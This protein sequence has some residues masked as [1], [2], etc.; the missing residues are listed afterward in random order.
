MARVARRQV[1]PTGRIDLCA[2]RLLEQAMEKSTDIPLRSLYG[3]YKAEIDRAIKRHLGK[4]RFHM[5]E[6]VKEIVQAVGHPTPPP[7]PPPAPA[8]PRPRTAATGPVV[9][10]K[11]G[12]DGV[13]A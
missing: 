12:K 13:Y 5:P 6:P 9:E 11:Q 2:I 4:Y 1:D 7:P 8:A 10:L 3:T